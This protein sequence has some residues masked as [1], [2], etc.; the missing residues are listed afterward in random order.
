MEFTT[1]FDLQSQTNRLL[2][3]RALEFLEEAYR[4]ITVHG[5]VLSNAFGPPFKQALPSADYNS[6][7]Y[8][9]ELFRLQSPLLTESLLV[10]FPQL[11]YMLK[12]SW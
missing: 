3:R 6:E 12:F 9:S 5:S 10:S 1:R 4:A 7:D 2:E 8:Q 11:S